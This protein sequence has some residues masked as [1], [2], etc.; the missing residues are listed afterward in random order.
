MKQKQTKSAVGGGARGT[1]QL[2]WVCGYVCMYVCL[3][4]RHTLLM[5]YTILVIKKKIFF[6]NKLMLNILQS[7]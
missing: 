7:L 5:H 1:C 4:H 3:Q 2:N 6:E